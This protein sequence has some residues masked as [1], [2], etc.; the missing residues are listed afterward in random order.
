MI[1]IDVFQMMCKPDG[2]ADEEPTD[3]EVILQ[4]ESLVLLQMLVNF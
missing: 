3:D 4:T 1:H 2:D